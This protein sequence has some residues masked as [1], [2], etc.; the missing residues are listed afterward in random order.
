MTACKIHGRNDTT[1]FQ[2]QTD[3]ISRVRAAKNYNVCKRPQ[4]KP[5]SHERCAPRRSKLK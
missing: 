1:K 5:G 2:C 4:V 3:R